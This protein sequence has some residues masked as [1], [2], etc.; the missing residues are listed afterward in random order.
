MFGPEDGLRD[1]EV[2]DDH[3]IALAER[4][5]SAAGPELERRRQEDSLLYVL[6]R[7]SK[8]IIVAAAVLVLVAGSILGTY[9]RGANDD[10]TQTMTLAEVLIPQELAP[11]YYL[12]NETTLGEI[13][14]ALE[15]GS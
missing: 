1:Y 11:W 15:G 7:W 10:E 3:L 6:A 5:V 8:P 9:R 14:S 13:V 4:I 2:G 12:E